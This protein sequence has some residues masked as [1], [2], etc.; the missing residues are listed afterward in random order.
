MDCGLMM[1]GDYNS[2]FSKMEEKDIFCKV[3]G[4]LSD[5]VD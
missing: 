3:V 4:Y 5:L 1:Q 2:D